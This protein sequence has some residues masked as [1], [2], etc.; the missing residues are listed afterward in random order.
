MKRDYTVWK[1]YDLLK[2]YFKLKRR[3]EKTKNAC[4][5]I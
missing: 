3:I 4:I 5:L 2:N 1:L